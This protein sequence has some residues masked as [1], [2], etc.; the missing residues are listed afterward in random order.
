MLMSGKRNDGTKKCGTNHNYGRLHF[1]SAPAPHAFTHVAT[2][3]KETKREGIKLSKKNVK[4]SSA[5][6]LQVRTGIYMYILSHFSPSFFKKKKEV[7]K[8]RYSRP[9]SV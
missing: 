1:P 8:K 7:E 2:V 6:T 5:S 9:C 4:M 3:N